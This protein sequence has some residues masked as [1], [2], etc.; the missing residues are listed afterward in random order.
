MRMRVRGFVLPLLGASVFLFAGCNEANE[1][2]MAK[3]A[4][5]GGPAKEYKSYGEYAQEKAQEAKNKAA[6]AKSKTAAPP[7]VE[8]AK[9]KGATPPTTEEAK[10]KT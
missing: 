5:G 4:P 9:G 1:E 7:K 10:P 3:T 6:E 8:A 2:G